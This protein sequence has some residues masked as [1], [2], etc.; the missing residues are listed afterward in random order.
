MVCGSLPT[1]ALCCESDHGFRRT[2]REVSVMADM[3]E[4]ARVY[5]DGWRIGGL[6]NSDAVKA[7]RKRRTLT[8]AE[9]RAG[10]DMTLIADTPE[11]LAEALRVQTEREGR[12]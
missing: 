2:D 9:F 1:V 11:A 3:G 10:L 5:G 6:P 7:V 12:L 4:L 8:D